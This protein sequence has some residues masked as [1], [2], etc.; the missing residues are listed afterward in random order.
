[1][2]VAKNFNT[3]LSP[4]ICDAPNTKLYKSEDIPLSIS[5]SLAEQSSLPRTRVRKNNHSN[6]KEYDIIN[7]EQQQDSNDDESDYTYNNSNHH[8]HYST[9]NSNGRDYS[10]KTTG[11][12]HRNINN[13]STI[14]S[15]NRYRWHNQS[16]E[17]ALQSLR[18]NS[19]NFAATTKTEAMTMQPNHRSHGSNR[20]QHHLNQI[21]NNFIMP[22]KKQ[23][24]HNTNNDQRSIDQNNGNHCPSRLYH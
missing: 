9:M 7:A 11:H 18:N 20:K 19:M 12:F 2:I 4:T 24:I 8:V 13:N 22:N 21:N 23:L 10:R 5:A 14:A 1:M 6:A 16:D 17:I 3:T 15:T